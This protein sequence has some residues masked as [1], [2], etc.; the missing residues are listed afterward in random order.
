MVNPHKEEA[1]SHALKTWKN[2]SDMKKEA[3]LEGLRR[4]V[5]STKPDR[6]LFA[7]WPMLSSEPDIREILT[8]FPGK[9][10]IPALKKDKTLVFRLFQG[11]ISLV[12]NS[13]GS[14]EP[15]PAQPEAGSPPGPHDLILI[16]ALGVNADGVRLGRGGGFY[17][18]TRDYLSKGIRVSLIPEELSNLHFPSE[19]HDLRLNHII[20]EI[21]V[22]DYK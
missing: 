2:L 10:Y 22:V 21:K 5:D 16:P 20:T 14:H 13:A 6:R 11:D 15:L 9:V 19:D 8:L 7:Y 4:F 3:M 1:R 18:R 17:D 12:R